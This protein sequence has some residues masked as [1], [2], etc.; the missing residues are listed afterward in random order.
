M[1]IIWVKLG[2]LIQCRFF[3]FGW[4]NLHKSFFTLRF[5]KLPCGM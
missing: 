1:S 3:V 5:L 4:N 2:L